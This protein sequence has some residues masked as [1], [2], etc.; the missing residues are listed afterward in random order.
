MLAVRLPRGMEKRLDTL[1][2]R[3]GRTKSYYVRH[4]LLENFEEM[5]DVFLA[6]KSMAEVLAGGPVYTLEE[7]RDRLGLK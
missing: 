5:E 4:A 6:D 2:K 1:A 7:V 3:T